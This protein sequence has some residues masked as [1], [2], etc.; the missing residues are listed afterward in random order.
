M[1]KVKHT[2]KKGEESQTS[3]MLE[4]VTIAMADVGMFAEIHEAMIRR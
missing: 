2:A 3:N 4:E 1:K